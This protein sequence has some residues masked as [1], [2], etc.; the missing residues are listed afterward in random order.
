MRSY[1]FYD[2]E[3]SGLSKA[4]DQVM[5]FAAIR[6]DE[7][8]NEMARY[9][10]SIAINKDIIPSATAMITHGQ[11]L[12]VEGPGED[13][14]IP[15]IRQLMMESYTWH[16]G[17][18]TL[19]FDDE[20]LRYS[21]Y[22]QLLDPYKHQYA[23]QCQRFDILPMVIM[24]HLF[25]PEGIKWP[26][27]DGVISYKLEHLNEENNWA[28][29]AA[30]DAMVDVE[31]TLGL[32]QTLQKKEAI[33]SYV[34]SYF[35]KSVDQNRTWQFC[36]AHPD[37]VVIGVGLS[38]GKASGCIAPMIVLPQLSS[39]NQIML[40]RLDHE[41]SGS[42]E[43]LWDHAKLIRKKWGEPPFILPLNDRFRKR[44]SSDQRDLMKHHIASIQSN[45]KDWQAYC[46]QCS[47]R[48]FDNEFSVDVDASLYLNGFYSADER[49][50][51]DAFL[52]E[53]DH[54]KSIIE[55][56]DNPALEEQ[57]LRWLWRFDDHYQQ[58]E[59]VERLNQKWLLSYQNNEMPLDLRGGKKR[60]PNDVM[61]E[62]KDIKENNN[63]L[64]AKQQSQLE[65]LRAYIKMR[66]E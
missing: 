38:L 27:I 65:D 25:S 15:V 7:C 34:L 1:L 50:L 53:P 16:G 8:L 60:S 9:E 39:S 42:K 3:T 54:R 52:S 57:M 26:S 31:V 44:L 30:H 21:F 64:S 46:Q 19:S 36:D 47:Q 5:Q 18:N 12:L 56:V 58:D 66:F 14:V 45:P 20:F 28:L 49:M 63:A 40:M 11:P 29:G 55:Q 35:Q 6:V 23:N 48:S 22:R 13:E 43:A 32:S 41:I 10:Y 33:W 17:Y 2:L 37:R 51:C 59:A 24:Y 62:I 61:A 4:F